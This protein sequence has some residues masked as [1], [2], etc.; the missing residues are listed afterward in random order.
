VATTDTVPL[1]TIRV[2]ILQKSIADVPRVPVP[3]DPADPVPIDGIAVG[4]YLRVRPTGAEHD[5]DAAISPWYKPGYK[6]DPPGA[7]PAPDADLLIEQLHDRGVLRGDLGAPLLLPDPRPGHKENGDLIAIAGMGPIGEFGVPELSLLARELCWSLAQLGKRHLAT[8]LIGATSKNLS[9]ADAVQGWMAGINRALVSAKLAN[10][11][12]LDCVTFVV[13]SRRPEA[14]Q[15]YLFALVNAL[16]RAKAAMLALS[17]YNFDI[18]L[19]DLPDVAA[20]LTES[21]G[22]QAAATRI[23]IDF[24]GDRCRYSAL[25][26]GAAIPEREF[27]I[28]PRRLLEINKRLLSA[29]NDDE[30]YRMGKF[31]LEFLFPRDLRAQLT[32][33]APVVL[34]C[35][36]DAAKM[37]WELA[38][39]PGQD[40][41]VEADRQYL[42]LA[43]GLTRQLRTVLAPPPEPLPPVGKTL[44]VLLVA[45]G[46]SE[47]PLPGAQKEAENLRQLF[48]RV[49]N[50]NRNNNRVEVTPLIGPAQATPLDVLLR[51]SENPPFDM[52][53]YAGHC[54]FNP[55]HPEKSGFLFSGGNV[56][57][58]NDLERIDRTPKFIFANACES[59]VLPSR[60]DLSSPQLPAAFAEAFFKKG[61]GNYICTAW[62][63]VD[64][65]A[66]QFALELYKYLLGDGTAPVEIYEAMRQ[67]RR[68]IVNTTTWGAYQHYGNPSFRL[69]RV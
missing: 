42:G 18:Q 66:L 8:V 61:V 12:A 51:L 44:R 55:M 6:P 63:V 22:R 35:N 2:R 27:T 57:T 14:Q 19:P 24:E 1:T 39:Q 60:P 43:R 15:R 69:L 32:G 4:H 67:A 62:P 20:P 33:S 23:S 65:A 48:E 5:I 46:C 25:T 26:D 56:L 30:R 3:P 11:Q 52:V 13:Q 53:H 54:F 49:T 59:G 34:A 37:Y 29:I 41:E 31:L 64:D 47:H 9:I 17:T 7:A 36:N 50:D 16:K 21:T 58:A 40:D 45:D 10:A 28:D 68:Q 38:A